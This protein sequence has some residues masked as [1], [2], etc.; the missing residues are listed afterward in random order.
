[1]H[2]G[3]DM[4]TAGPLIVKIQAA[5]PNQSSC[6]R[7]LKAYKFVNSK[8]RTS[9]GTLTAEQFKSADEETTTTGIKF[10]SLYRRTNAKGE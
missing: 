8:E 5:I 10:A 4:P 6:E 1:M 2:G 3:N 9:M 7:Y